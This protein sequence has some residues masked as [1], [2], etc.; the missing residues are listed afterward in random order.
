MASNDTTENILRRNEARDIF[1]GG[2][3]G[4]KR[5]RYLYDAPGRP[6]SETMQSDGNVR[7]NANCVIVRNAPPNEP[8]YFAI[9][10]TD[11]INGFDRLCS[12]VTARNNANESL[13][14]HEV[15][16]DHRPR[17]IVFDMDSGDEE[18]YNRIINHLRTKGREIHDNLATWDTYDSSAPATSAGS[19]DAKFSRH[20]V[21]GEVCARNSIQACAYAR[22]LIIGLDDADR[23]H[24]DASLLKPKRSQMLRMCYS[25][26]IDP[27]GRKRKKMPTQETFDDSMGFKDSLIQYVQNCAMLP[28]L[29]ITD[30]KFAGPRDPNHTF[31]N[32]GMIPTELD[33]SQTDAIAQWCNANSFRVD[34]PIG[35]GVISVL[36]TGSSHCDICGAT[37]DHRDGYMVIRGNSIIFKCLR[38]RDNNITRHI[39]I[40]Q[41]T[42]SRKLFTDPRGQWTFS[43]QENLQTDLTKIE[44]KTKFI[45]FMQRNLVFVR[46]ASTPYYLMR[47]RDVDNV[48][49]FIATTNL[50]HRGKKCLMSVRRKDS[51]MNTDVSFEHGVES[52]IDD[53]SYDGADFVPYFRTSPRINP[54]FV[55]LW[56]GYTHQI[57]PEINM[58]FAMPLLDHFKHI[59]C[60]DDPVSFEYLLNW[61]AYLI[62]DPGNPRRTALI[63][64]GLQGCGKSSPVEYIGRSIIGRQYFRNCNI[65]RISARFNDDLAQK[66]LILIDETHQSDMSQSAL[67]AKLKDIITND[68][69]AIETK[70]LP[71]RYVRN[72]MHFIFGSNSELPIRIEPAERRYCVFDCAPIMADDRN[73]YFGAL[74]GAIENDEASRH[75]FTFFATRDIS[76][77][78]IEHIPNTEALIHCKIESMTPQMRFIYEI[79]CGNI[80]PWTARSTPQIEPTSAEDGAPSTLLEDSEYCVTSQELFDVFNA[81]CERNKILRTCRKMTFDQDISRIIGSAERAYI[82]GTRQ[83]AHKFTLA[84]IMRV[85]RQLIGNVDRALLP[86]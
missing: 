86:S 59:W 44:G 22:K 38:A 3:G 75:I 76:H 15:I 36:R 70:G 64:R 85:I 43:E 45:D 66:I 68:T 81:W 1:E 37:H 23:A 69:V 19:N 2:I 61:F 34:R 31:D 26:K 54:R 51:L 56:M 33:Q 62:Q 67:E 40:W 27:S 35:P 73:A 63:I 8:S 5:Y 60:R 11:F 65:E 13:F 25:T 47:V 6:E 14:L 20:I 57:V 41:K 18:I 80:E 24:L 82:N 58:A 21:S 17:R 53:I 10:G 29:E 52:I 30:G 4:I 12:Y 83:R 28:D 32:I 16:V 55:N 42:D 39:V 74:Y 46:F 78:N 77:F 72:A 50:L 71:I 49:V 7:I 84:K 48:I 9:I 79:G